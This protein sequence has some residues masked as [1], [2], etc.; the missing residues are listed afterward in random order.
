MMSGDLA[1]AVTQFGEVAAEAQAA[2]DEIWSVL[3]FGG[4]RIALANQGVAAAARAA[5]E[6]TLEGGAE[7]GGRF[8]VVGHVVLGFAALAAGDTAAA[9]EV[10]EAARQHMPVVSG[11]TAALQRVWNAEAALADGDLAAP[12]SAPTRP[13]RRQRAGTRRWR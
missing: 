10:R 6:A 8:A 4:Q 9:H 2:H 12:A 5:A 1:G 11:A 3:S 7:L 13:S